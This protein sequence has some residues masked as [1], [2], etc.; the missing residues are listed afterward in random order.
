M[1]GVFVLDVGTRWGCEEV[2]ERVGVDRI[3]GWDRYD[4]VY[5]GRGR[6]WRW[7]S[8]D[9]CDNNGQGKVFDGDVF[10]EGK[11]EEWLTF[12][13][14]GGVDGN[15]GDGA[16]KLIDETILG[17]DEVLVIDNGGVGEL[18]DQIVEVMTGEF[19]GRN[20]GEN[21][22][23]GLVVDKRRRR[24]GDEDRSGGGRCTVG[25]SG[26][27]EIPGIMRTIEEVLDLLGGGSE[28][29]CVDIVDGRP[30]E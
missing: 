26:G 27:W 1:V 7:D 16:G 10:V 9:Q 3:C 28:V 17:G 23:E 24:T 18:D 22:E 30:V 14:V 11:G 21:V 12:D 20:I 8:G 5:D 15:G 25:V 13:N 4:S 29:C 2:R 6:C 19:L